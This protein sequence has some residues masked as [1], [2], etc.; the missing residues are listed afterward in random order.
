MITT[1]DD[2]YTFLHYIVTNLQY[3]QNLEIAMKVENYRSLSPH[4]PK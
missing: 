4:L 1:D 3:I 2:I